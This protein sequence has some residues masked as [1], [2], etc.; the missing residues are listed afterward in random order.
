MVKSEI[1]C[2]D[3]LVCGQFTVEI[4]TFISNISARGFFASFHANAN[5]ISSLR[6]PLFFE[7]VEYKAAIF[8]N[9]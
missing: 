5:V 3:R 1:W 8:C 2:E 6:Q 4:A 7:G 9:D